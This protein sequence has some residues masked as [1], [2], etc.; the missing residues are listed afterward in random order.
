MHR[1][2]GTEFANI[3]AAP[4][5]A[6][7]RLRIQLLW[8]PED[9]VLWRQGGRSL[10][11]YAA[12]NVD[13]TEALLGVGHADLDVGNRQGIPEIQFASEGRLFHL[14]MLREWG[15][16]ELLLGAKAT[17][18]VLTGI[19]GPS[20]AFIWACALGKT[21][22]EVR[23]WLTRFPHWDLELRD[24][25]MR[26]PYRR[27]ERLKLFACLRHCALQSHFQSMGLRES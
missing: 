15:V 12:F 6:L 1:C 24:G 10:L 17:P 26:T 27:V 14:A 16:A 20:Y 22:R 4:R 18:D 25:P 11:W 21:D 19:D 9:D 13:A 23:G 3:N 8:N 7:E 5:G 2:D